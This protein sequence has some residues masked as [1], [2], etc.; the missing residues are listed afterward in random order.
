MGL[1][2]VGLIDGGCKIGLRL[3]GLIDVGCKIL[4]LIDGS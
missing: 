3:V 2:L 1:W 4:G